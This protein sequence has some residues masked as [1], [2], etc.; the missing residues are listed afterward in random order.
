MLI[1]S[2]NYVLECL[3]LKKP[4]VMLQEARILEETTFNKQQPVLCHAHSFKTTRFTHMIK[5]SL[6]N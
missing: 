6:V 3:V 2:S 5:T 4:T 1:V